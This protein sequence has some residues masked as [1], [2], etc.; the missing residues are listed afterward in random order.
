MVRAT[1]LIDLSAGVTDIQLRLHLETA[2]SSCTQALSLVRP[3]LP[4]L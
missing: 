3:L 2:L 1:Y 4:E